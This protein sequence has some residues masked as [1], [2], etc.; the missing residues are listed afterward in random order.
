MLKTPN[1]S[2]ASTKSRIPRP[3]TSKA[4]ADIEVVTE[5]SVTSPQK[6]PKICSVEHKV[7]PPV[8]PAKKKKDGKK[9]SKVEEKSVSKK[10][11]AVVH[12]AL[13]VNQALAARKTP[14]KPKLLSY[15]VENDELPD[16]QAKQ[17][18]DEY[19]SN[20][21]KVQENL[22]KEQKPRKDDENSKTTKLQEQG[23]NVRT[24]IRKLSASPTRL[25]IKQDEIDKDMIPKK[26]K[27]KKVKEIIEIIEN[28]QEECKPSKMSKKKETHEKDET[29]IETT[30]K[31]TKKELP[32]RENEP[33]PETKPLILK[34]EDK[35]K[36]E[37]LYMSKLQKV[38][39]MVDLP[40][41][42]RACPSIPN[43]LCFLD[44]LE[45][46]KKLKHFL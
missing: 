38:S 20:D 46:L 36:T 31:L 4:P 35:R 27:S 3:T 21:V 39:T 1:A 41:Q 30:I 40:T 16:I 45:S 11:T 10:I 17:G 15:K 23:E 32:K 5:R 33:N 34:I 2:A 18:Q 12:Q 43:F 24:E 9:K 6:Y 13:A 19:H 25:Q 44:F 22:T 8:K 28:E 29:Q 37:Q 14:T 7:L 42:S 26:K